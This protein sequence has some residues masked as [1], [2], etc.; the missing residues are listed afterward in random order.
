M[1]M[2]EL[3]Q[4]PSTINR[5]VV[6]AKY[7]SIG[8]GAKLIRDTLLLAGTPCVELVAVMAK[9]SPFAEKAGMKKITVQ[10]PAPDILRIAEGLKTLGFDLQL[11]GSQHYVLPRLEKLTGEQL[12]TL[13]SWLQRSGHPRFRKEFAISRHVPYGRT[14]EFKKCIAEA[15]LP[16]LGRLLKIVGMLLQTKVY[17]FWKSPALET[18]NG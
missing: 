10:E 14:A 1:S 6:H 9:Y 11:L 5:V 3:N 13:R 16:K 7:R 4:Q 18:H 8:L 15:D 12:T 2:K 17:L